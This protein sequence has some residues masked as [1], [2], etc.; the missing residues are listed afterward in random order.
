MPKEKVMQLLKTDRVYFDGKPDVYLEAFAIVGDNRPKKSAML[1]IPGGGYHHVCLTYEGESVALSYVSQGVNAFVLN[2]RAEICDVFPSHL[3]YAAWAMA[4]I[5]DHAEEFDV[6]PERVFALGFSAGGHL[7]ASLAVMHKIAEKNLGYPENYAK[8][9]GTVLCYPVVSAYSPTHEGSFAN[10]LN[11]P[12]S[13]LSDEERRKFSI[14]CNVTSETPPAFI[15]H[16]A[17][18]T[19]VPPIGSL[20]L[21]EAYLSA[22]VPVTMHLYPYG[23]HGIGLATESSGVSQ[24]IAKMWFSYSLEWM[25][26]V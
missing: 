8:P 17:E 5:K 6:D 25:K 26:T 12:F 13:E 9:R 23:A 1:I 20:H 22:G 10:L 19:A 4:Y 15:W 2:Y 24:P 7:C 14:E 11:K 16:T 3:E 21:A 18:D